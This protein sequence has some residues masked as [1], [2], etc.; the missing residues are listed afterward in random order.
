MLARQVGA[1]D[2]AATDLGQEPE[3]AQVVADR[4]EVDRRGGSQEPVAVEQEL[5]LRT[6]LREPPEHLVGDPLLAR[7][8]AETRFLVDEPHRVLVANDRQ[9]SQVLVGLRLLAV[10]PGVGQLLDQALHQRAERIVCRHACH[11]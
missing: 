1:S 4:G 11:Q 9:T 8:L 10:L 7:F 2:R 5:Q 3:V 6:V